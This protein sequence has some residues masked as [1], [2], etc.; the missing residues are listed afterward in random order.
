[1]AIVLLVTLVVPIVALPRRGEVLEAKREP[2]LL[3]L[4]RASLA[5]GFA[6]LYPPIVLLV[7]YSFNARRLVTVWGG[8]STR[9]YGALLRTSPCSTRSG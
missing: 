7:V 3:R 2:P 6:F 1:M 9:W 5:L 8:F 4:Q